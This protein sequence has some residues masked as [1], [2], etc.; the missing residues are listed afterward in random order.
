LVR[1]NPIQIISSE[2]KIDD[3]NIRFAVSQFSS[4]VVKELGLDCSKNK[5]EIGEFMKQ[6]FYYLKYRSFNHQSLEIMLEAFA[7]GYA[8]KSGEGE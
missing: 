3:I 4:C 6:L 1:R 8:C 7:S 5:V 2:L